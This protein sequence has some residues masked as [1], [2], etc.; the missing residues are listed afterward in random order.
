MSIKE[1]SDK[2]IDNALEKIMD[3]NIPLKLEHNLRLIAKLVYNLRKDFEALSQEIRN[4]KDKPKRKR[5]NNSLY[6]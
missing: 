1:A 3:V 4:K 6:S 2:K 5:N